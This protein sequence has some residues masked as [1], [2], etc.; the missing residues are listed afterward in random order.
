MKQFQELA[1]PVP[2]ASALWRI[3]FST[4]LLIAGWLL[5]ACGA[6]DP[7][8]PNADAPLQ[9][10]TPHPTFTPTA[11][12]N[13]AGQDAQPTV[14]VA[15][16]API[17]TPV[18]ATSTQV[19]TTQSASTTTAP[20]A[21]TPKPDPKAKVKAIVNTPLVNIRSGPSTDDEILTTVDRGEEYEI[22]GKNAKGDWWK[23]CCV[24]DKP[25]WVSTELVDTDGPVDSVAVAK[26]EAQAEATT[27][28]TSANAVRAATTA[29]TEI[30]TSQAVTATT[31]SDAFGFTL[32]TQEQ[33]PESKQVRIYL[34]VYDGDSNA[35]E[36]YSLRVTKD[37]GE[38]PANGTSFGGRPGFTWP[39]AD[40]R[41]RFQN[42]KI[43]FPGVAPAGTWVVQLSK[44]SKPVGP[45]A[46][47]QLKAN[48]SN[49]E[50]Y[51]RYEK[52]K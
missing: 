8:A 45:P 4:L 35:L 25:G 19:T 22:V 42:L 27:A 52:H 44:D 48:D 6:S 12:T 49:Q 41:Q 24:D 15:Q 30:S 7:A 11:P 1:N 26:D 38:A 37:G 50:L 20:P 5:V 31:P 29:P 34:Y 28:P 18:A 23:V 51:V 3:L 16:V 14:A 40:V 39:V 21:N 10:R 43:E 32:I 2:Q 36:G 47:F 13:G 9:I 46:T 17:T 33:F